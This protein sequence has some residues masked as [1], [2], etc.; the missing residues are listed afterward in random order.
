MP[1]KNT[2]QKFARRIKKRRSGVVNGSRLTFEQL[3]PRQLLATLT[4]TSNADAGV[5]SLRDVITQANTNAGADT[6]EFDASLLCDC[7][8]LLLWDRSCRYSAAECVVV[9]LGLSV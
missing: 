4:V 9:S 6:I 2:R 5:G 8:S 7:E 1:E 3:E